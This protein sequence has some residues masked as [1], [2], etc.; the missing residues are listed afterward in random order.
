MSDNVHRAARFCGVAR[1]DILELI[2]AAFR[3][4]HSAYWVATR[5]S[6]RFEA[7]CRYYSDTH[8]LIGVENTDT[9]NEQNLAIQG[10][11][12]IE[13]IKNEIMQMEIEK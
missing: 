10:K 5:F 1:K 6:A 12:K 9:A 4:T 8:I 7:R 3:V 11:D 2:S 13:S